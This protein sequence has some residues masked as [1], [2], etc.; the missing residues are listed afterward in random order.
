MTC[1]FLIW[2]INPCK[3]TRRLLC[4]PL[5]KATAP[6]NFK[7]QGWSAQG[8]WLTGDAVWRG[9]SGLGRPATPKGAWILRTTEKE[10][11][12][13]HPALAP[14]S[15]TPQGPPGTLLQDSV[16]PLSQEGRKQ[17]PMI[18]LLSQRLCVKNKIN[19]K[20]HI[21]NPIGTLQGRGIESS[22]RIFHALKVTARLVILSIF[23]KIHGSHKSGFGWKVL[24]PNEE[25]T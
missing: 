3:L 25:I 16:T 4:S 6:T 10:E 5:Y 22:R 8:R 17:S 12:D 9:Y 23:A 15:A 18:R 19:N 7:W 14:A 2:W 1:P 21:F 24:F 11:K 13:T 20:E